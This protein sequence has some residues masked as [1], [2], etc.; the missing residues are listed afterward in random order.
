MFALPVSGE[1]Q[2]FLHD[3]LAQRD[4]GPAATDLLQ[5]AMYAQRKLRREQFCASPSKRSKRAEGVVTLEKHRNIPRRSRRLKPAVQISSG[6]RTARIK[7]R[8]RSEENTSSGYN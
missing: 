7:T 3:E 4:G 1:A 8:G 5:F 2:F 6:T